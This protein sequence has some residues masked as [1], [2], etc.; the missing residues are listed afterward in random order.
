MPTSI[1]TTE[2][3]RPG[4]VRVTG[5]L[6][7]RLLLNYDR[8]ERD[9]YR[10]PTASPSEMATFY[11]GTTDNIGWPGDFVGRV[12][13]SLVHLDRVTGRT[14]QYLDRILEHLPGQFNRK[15]YMG[16]EA[17]GLDEQQLAGNGWLVAG[18]VSHWKW[19]GE[20]RSL[21]MALRITEGLY[22][23][24]GGKV[25]TYP[26]R[27]EDHA[28]GGEQAGTILGRIG[29]WNLSSDIGCV[30]LGLEGI[31]RAAV[32]TGREDV[33]GLVEEMFGV[34]ATID[35]IALSAQLHSSLTGARMFL[36]YH[37]A[38]GRPEMLEASRRIYG[39][40][41]TLGI[42]ENYANYNWFN[43][44]SWTEPC[45]IVD[46]LL[47]AMALHRQTGD[48]S[49]L[50]DAH[51]IYFNAICYAQKPHGG[52]GCDQCVGSEATFLEKTVFDVPWCCNMR[53]SIGLS[54]VVDH[55]YLR[56]GEDLDIAWYFD[57]RAELEF[58]S[59]RLVVS[60]TTHYPEEGHIVLTIA[61]STLPGE[62]QIR[63]FIP[64]WVDPGKVD[65]RVD[66]HQVP[67]PVH[68]GYVGVRRAWKPGDEIRL[69]FPVAIRTES[70]MNSRSLPGHFTY[71]HG[72][73][74]LGT[75]IS[76]ASKKREDLRLTGPARYHAPVP[77]G[78]DLY[79]VNDTYRLTEQE[80]LHDRK[81]ILFR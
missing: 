73:L 47:L 31:V 53:G 78:I 60:Q 51:H 15:G 59:G 21:E 33:K 8:L 13:L 40:F 2:L 24:L 16:G 68:K 25:S 11:R 32:E 54:G 74:I 6:S 44:P 52:F 56:R 81:K 17:D 30:F 39:L 38:F 80:A 70:T 35:V 18:L 26:I 41:R 63:F 9:D 27:P 58:P 67:A 4:A 5:E 64:P 36:H 65:L 12:I 62:R 66:G 77:D 48:P 45:A 71:R 49:Y 34:F 7:D 14:P 20:Q 28:I 72:P 37:E 10:P 43:R 46:A 79:P 50:D 42:T 19:T 55:I 69:T 23:R 1:P 3:F 61:E 57:S 75:H 76:L 22:L 29:Q